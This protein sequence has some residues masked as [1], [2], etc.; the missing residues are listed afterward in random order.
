MIRNTCY[1]LISILIY[2]SQSVAIPAEDSANQPL[3]IGVMA[4]LTGD[5]ASAGEEIKRG[6]ELARDVLVKKGIV[7][8]I[9]F[10]DACLPAQGV[11][12]IKKLIEFDKINALV[13]N[14]C[15]VS[16]NAIAP[17]INKNKIIVLQNSISPIKLITTSAYFYTTWPSIEEEVTAM[18]AGLSDEEIAR[19][20]VFYN[21]SPWGM[22]YA[23]AFRYEI[24]RRKG[25]VL[26]DLSQGFGVHDFRTEVARLKSQNI[27]TI[28]VAHTGSPLVSFMKQAVSIGIK[29]NKIITP[30]DAEDLE[31]LK[32][33]GSAG[34]GMSLYSTDSVGESSVRRKFHDQYLEKY[35]REPA[36]LGRHAYD[37]LV[38]VAES[39]KECSK[40]TECV[41][42]KLLNVKDCNGASGVFTIMPQ[43]LAK[44]TFAKK[45]ARKETFT[46]A[47]IE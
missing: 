5:Y 28:L 29:A 3:R 15:L 41:Q 4:P 42:A 46:F 26:M 39:M 16:L 25:K 43:R 17:I 2:V 14:Y 11:P 34:D 12:A 9:T 45:I 27:T 1:L 21:E 32:A 24:L 7:T 37:Q 23:E 19:S 18:V 13:S 6:I 44:R 35:R 22:T 8:A 20:A 47:A 30:S 38:L 31:I 40:V 33:A 36:P 10:E